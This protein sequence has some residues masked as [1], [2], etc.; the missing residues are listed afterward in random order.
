MSER[1]QFTEE[2]A[3]LQECR[4]RMI[5]EIGKAIIGQRDVIDQMLAAL[6]CNAHCLLIGVPGLAKTTL[7]RA[8]SDLLALSFKRIQFTPDLMPSDIT[9][10][11]VI[12]ENE[13][14]RQREFKFL[15]GPVFANVVLADEINRTPPKTQAALLE[16]MQER[17]VSVGNVTYELPKPFFVIATQNPIEQEGT[18]PLPEAQQ[19]RFMFNIHV[20]YPN[21]EEENEIYRFA[22]SVEM[23]SL[24]SLMKADDIFRIQHIVDRVVVSDYVIQY[25]TD[26]VR[27]TRPADPKA[28]AFIKELV[29]WG[30]GPRAGLYLI[31]GAKALAAM[32]GRINVSTEDIRR[33]SVPVLRHRLGTNFQAESRGVD[34]VKL[35][36]M[37]IKAVPEPKLA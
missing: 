1:S 15:P 20:A 3:W 37:L 13:E 18:Y 19:D 9:G 30:A 14:T 27:A 12:E 34:A 25:V 28:P 17:Q 10:T 22:T 4:Q 31:K 7:V 23:P 36:G 21:P 5:S 6:F 2:L 32:E 29:D 35:V 11:N 26:L 8:L 24:Q 33:V 16:S